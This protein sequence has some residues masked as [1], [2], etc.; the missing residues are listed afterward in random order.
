MPAPA[1]TARQHLT[2]L[3]HLYK[4]LARQHHRDLRPLLASLVPQD[5]IVIDAG[6]HAGQFTKL[7]AGLAPGGRIYAFEPGSYARSVLEPVVSL[8]RLRNVTIVA[9]ALSDSEGT[10]DLAIPLKASGSFGF[11]LSH[12]GARS[13]RRE[14]RHETVSTTTLDGFASEQGINRLDFIKADVEGWEIRLLRGASRTLASH[15]PTLLLELVRTHLARADTDPAEAWAILEPLGYEAIKLPDRQPV[16]KFAG[17]G[18][19]IFDARDGHLSRRNRA[20]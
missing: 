7:F 3:A 18:D 11:G 13:P 1:L 10:E 16:P 20:A 14:A 17:D 5:G 19:Y 8:R 15:R 2:H 6:A 12:L 9:R 4:A